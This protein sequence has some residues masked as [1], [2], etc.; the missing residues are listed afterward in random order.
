MLREDD[1]RVP[2]REMTRWLVP[3]F[4]VVVG[5]ALFFTLGRRTGSIAAPIHVDAGSP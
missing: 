3:V 4:L 5:L 1:S 2:L